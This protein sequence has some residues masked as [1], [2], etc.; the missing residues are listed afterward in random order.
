MG[1]DLLFFLT[2]KKGNVEDFIFDVGDFKRDPNP[3]DGTV[4]KLYEQTK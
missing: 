1:K 2:L 3:L 4:G